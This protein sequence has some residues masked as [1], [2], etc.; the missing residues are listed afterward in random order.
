MSK[1]KAV[2][3]TKSATEPAAPKTAVQEALEVTWV[4]KGHLKSLQIA[5]LRVGA[6]LARVRDQKLYA[7]L[8]HP[9]TACG[10][11]GAGARDS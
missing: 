9:G 10:L 7:A 4:L 1:V 8:K 11:C 3:K 6:L 5:Y 2:S